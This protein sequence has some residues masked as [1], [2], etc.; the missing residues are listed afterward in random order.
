MLAKAVFL[1]RDGTLNFDYGYIGDPD[2][3][4]LL[5]GV[6]EGLN[7]LK[8]KLGFLLIVVSNQSGIHRGLIT[9][10]QVKSVNDRLKELLL[11]NNIVLDA[12]YYCPA[13]PDYSKPDECEC[14]KPSPKM[15][16]DAAKDHKIE[17]ANSF[18]IGDSSSDV[19][20]GLN[21]KVKS[22]LVKTGNG[23]ESI[24]ILQ[25]QNKIPSFVAENILDACKYIESHTIGVV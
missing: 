8:N 12:V 9:E 21:A 2:K 22:I 7:L 11:K 5:P 15:I 1:D 18:L 6:I 16:L 23:K 19:L 25:N 13:H 3:V 4:I 20:A 17:L 14:R 10:E 24:S